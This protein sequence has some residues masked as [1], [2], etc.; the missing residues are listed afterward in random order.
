MIIRRTAQTRKAR[1]ADSTKFKNAMN[2]CRHLLPNG[3]SPQP[4][5]AEELEKMRQ[6]AKCM[7]QHGI[8]A[9]SVE[10][11][12]QAWAAANLPMQQGR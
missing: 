12:T 7:R 10:G 5:S 1:S 4:P 6:F 3:G 11:G 2:K 9:V 8:D